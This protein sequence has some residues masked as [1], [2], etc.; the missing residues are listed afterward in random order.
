MRVRAGAIAVLVVGFC[1]LVTGCVAQT[2]Q[3]PTAQQPTEMAAT[4]EM[5]PAEPPPGPIAT[6]T[7][8][9]PTAQQSS[10]V[11][12]TVETPPAEP[13]PHPIATP[14]FQ[15]PTRQQPPKMTAVV[16]ATPTEPPP[17]SGVTPSLSV[18]ASQGQIVPV[19]T[20]PGYQA[21]PKIIVA[22]EV[23]LVAWPSHPTAYVSS[24]PISAGVQVR[25]VGTDRNGA[26]LLVLHDNTLGWM[27]SFYSGTGIG[28]LELAV[29][30]E[31]RSDACARYL[32]ATFTPEETWASSS[33]STALVQGI[34]Y[35]PQPERRSEEASPAIEIDGLGQV[36]VSK[37]NHTPLAASS[38]ILMFTFALEDLQENSRIRFRLTG[39]DH[40]P[41]VFQAAFFSNDCP[42]GGAP[43]IAVST[44]KDDGSPATQPP[45]QLESPIPAPTSTP[46]VVRSGPAAGA[47]TAAEL[48]G[49][50]CTYYTVR[51][52]DT[53]SSIARRYGST[54]Q[55]IAQ[56]NGIVNPSLI[57]IDQ[58]LCIP[59]APTG[60][61]PAVVDP[62]FW[63]DQ[64]VIR[65]G[66]CTI[67][68]WD[69]EGIKEVYLD[70]IGQVGQDS[71]SVCPTQT[72]TFT[73]TVVQRDGRRVEH[74][75]TIQISGQPSY[76]PLTI[77][78][79]L[80]GKRCISRGEYI[81]EFS[82]WATGGNRSYTYYSDSQKIGGPVTGGVTYK[83]QWGACCGVPG[84]F[85]VR[86]GDG[87]E[88][89]KKFWV[90]HPDCSTY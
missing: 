10:K 26:W 37:I 52:G 87:Q 14:T 86:S 51:S 69:V 74:S 62:H 31:S 44:P 89:Q 75:I 84:T 13:P 66:E 53:M 12:V 67:L 35:R 2:S 88:A 21:L 80:N 45:S 71:Q 72:Q 11:A 60:S 32:G 46:I 81:A 42:D 49:S 70:D 17:H 90:E 83:L 41:L 40:E 43:Q 73:L 61:K 6:P 34:I 4:V 82:V 22:S 30:A 57:R 79:H 39:F 78:W 56:A 20:T 48:T 85:I 59:S 63:A 33:S 7:F 28:T 64:M 38:E 68:R 5:T 23:I 58:V 55:A 25:V 47:I 3:V 18:V 9:I 1:I 29:V 19:D 50:L 24:D 76:S 77:D 54:V 65:P 16:E 15:M 8:Q 27:P 36:S